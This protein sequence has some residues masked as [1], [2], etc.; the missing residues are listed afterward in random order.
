MLVLTPVR[1]VASAHSPGRSRKALASTSYLLWPPDPFGLGIGGG[2]CQM[3]SLIAILPSSCFLWPGRSCS[4]AG[5]LA[6]QV[7]AT[8]GDP[9]GR[10]LPPPPVKR[11]PWVNLLGGGGTQGRGRGSG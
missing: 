6:V 2:S 5:L 7:G 1:V 9:L 8:A 3:I 10:G 11:R 4:A